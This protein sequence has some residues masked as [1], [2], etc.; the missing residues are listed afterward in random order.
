[1]SCIVDNA[2]IYSMVVKFRNTIFPPPPQLSL[3]GGLR[4]QAIQME[5]DP[6]IA[7]ITQKAVFI[8]RCLWQ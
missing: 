2:A 7:E 4:C 6:Y 1:M 8:V 3:L 5:H